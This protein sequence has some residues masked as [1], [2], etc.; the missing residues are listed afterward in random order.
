MTMWLWTYGPWREGPQSDIGPATNKTITW[1]LTGRHEASYNINGR[2][3]EAYGLDELISDLWVIRDG[4][5][6]FRG[7]LGS[8]DDEGDPDSHTVT[9]SW[10]D[11]RAILDR[12]QLYDDDPFAYPSADQA[13]I[14]W[15]LI[16]ATQARAG[17]NLGVVRGIGQITSVARTD[18][19]YEAGAKIGESIDS[20]AK[21]EFGFDWDITPAA[22]PRIHTHTLDI[23]SPYRGADRGVVLD[24]GALVTKFSRRVDP[25]GYSNAVRA[26]GGGDTVDPVIVQAP[27]L[28][29]RPEGRW[30]LAVN[31]S[32]LGSDADL[33]AA[34]NQALADSQLVTPSYTLTLRAGAWRGRDHIWL[35]DLVRLRIRSGCLDVDDLYRVQEI[36]A[37]W[38]A[39]TDADGVTATITVGAIPPDRRLHLRA[40][41]RRLAAL[42]R[43]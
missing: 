7:R 3:A 6:L 19:I 13:D 15:G 18:V 35:G 28:A 37:A 17:G 20:L 12:R 10:A 33:E 5:C 32:E 41:D 24:Y 34:A 38:S 29:T 42:E 9:T 16:S 27:D 36:G 2:V 26:A 30:D 31:A 25:A 40:L 14:V 22:D 21:L 4:T 23:W 11:Y 43:R 1:R 39:D 8:R